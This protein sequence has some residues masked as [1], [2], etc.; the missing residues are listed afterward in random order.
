MTHFNFNLRTL[1]CASLL[2]LGALAN[3]ETDDG[4]EAV[5]ERIAAEFDTIGPANVNPSP[6]PGWYTIQ[7]GTIVAYVSEDARYLLQGDLIDLEAQVNLSELARDKARSDIVASLRDDEVISFAP[8]NIKHSI[9]VFTDVGCTFCRR[10]HNEIATYLAAGIEVRYVL[11]PRNGPASPDW[12][13]SE[14]VWCAKDRNSALTA[15]KQD[16]AFETSK[17]DASIIQD[18]YALGQDVGLSGTPAIVLE[19]GTLIAGYLPADVLA[20]Q[21]EQSQPQAKRGGP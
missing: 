6:I 19:D 1:L 11:Y 18:H 8:E 13:E 15:A 14:K 17:C 9:T 10:L 20:E 21:L 16:R 3:A 2:T 7:K 12:V 5:R 4:I